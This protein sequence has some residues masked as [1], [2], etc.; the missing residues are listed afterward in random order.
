MRPLRIPAVFGPGRSSSVTPAVPG[1]CRWKMFP[2]RKGGAV[3]GAADGRCRL[4]FRTGA[5]PLASGNR[6]GLTPLAAQRSGVRLERPRGAARCA[7]AYRYGGS[8][9]REAPTTRDAATLQP[10][11]QRHEWIVGT[12][13]AVATT[14]VGS[15][16]AVVAVVVTLAGGVRAD[17]RDV[18]ADLR[19]VR[20]GVHSL[21]ARLGAVDVG[22]GN[23]DL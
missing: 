17:L 13:I 18:R 8:R 6:R 10:H 12:G 11:E 3:G 1:R 21:D 5:A 4:C 22:F 15:V 16:A 9:L 23:V 2:V 20:A 7:P 14:S 19:A